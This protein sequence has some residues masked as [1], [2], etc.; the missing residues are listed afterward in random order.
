MLGLFMIGSAMLA[1]STTPADALVGLVVM[2]VIG[3]G[4]AA[5]GGFWWRFVT[6]AD[7]RRR[8]EYQDKTVLGVAARHNGVVTIARVAVETDMSPEEAREA[9]ERLCI[10]GLAQPEVL[11]DGAIEYRFGGLLGR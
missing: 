1:V 10:R 3:A 7:A 5:A 6:S 11:D 9:I 8:I 4:F 2:M